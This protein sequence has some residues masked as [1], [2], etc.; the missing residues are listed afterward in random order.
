MKKLVSEMICMAG[1][2]FALLAVSLLS[3]S[4]LPASICLIAAFFSIT[5]TIYAAMAVHHMENTNK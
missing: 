3:Y 2:V 5:T 4:E 1:F